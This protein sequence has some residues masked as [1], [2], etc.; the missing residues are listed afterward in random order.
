MGGSYCLSS[1]PQ[2]YPESCK[3]AGKCVCVPTV[4]EEP[5]LGS[6]PSPKLYFFLKWEAID[7]SVKWH[8]L[9]S[10]NRLTDIKNKLM[11]SKVGK[12]K[13]GAWEEHTHT[14]TYNYV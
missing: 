9:Q 8:Y 5:F 13:S 12:D 10:R 14:D 7:V 11:V 4:D 1:L 2:C 6:L 3:L